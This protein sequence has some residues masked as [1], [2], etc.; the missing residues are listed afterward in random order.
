MART[1]DD[2]IR[3]VRDLGLF[4][5]GVAILVNQAFIAASVSGELLATGMGLVLSPLATRIDD[6][7][8]RARR[9]AVDSAQHDR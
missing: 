5:L 2:V 1:L 3:L 7:A 4:L 6:A 8:K 9:E